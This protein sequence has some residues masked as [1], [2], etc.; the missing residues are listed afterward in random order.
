MPATMSPQLTY[1]EYLSTNQNFISAFG[2]LRPGIDLSQAR[3]ELALLGAAINRAIPSDPDQPDE[4]TSASATTL[5]EAR[6]DKTVRRSLFILLGAVAL[7]H[8]L[9][10]ANVVNLL[11][12]RAAERR[13]ES[14]VRIALGSSGRR[15]F[16]HLVSEGLTL[17]LLGGAFGIALAAWA[18]AVI[19]PPTNVWA[20][21]N[22][23]GSLAPFDAPA[24]RWA[25]MA[26]GIA[27]VG[28]TA[29][30]ISIPPALAAFRIDVS[31]GIKAGSR[32]IA[33]GGL[34]LRR[35][36]S[37]G[38]IVGLEAALAML[39]VVSA[40]LLIESFSR[41]QKAGLGVEPENVLTFWVIP[42]EARVPPA[43]APEFVSRILEAITS[44]PG[45]VSA[46]VDGGGPL[47]GTANS[48]L[49]VIGR[50]DPAPGQAPAVLRHYIAPDH[51]R[52]LAIPCCE[53]GASPTPIPQAAR[54]SS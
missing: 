40:G 7:L 34:S 24:F 25:E 29:L 17:S 9:A 4:R 48:T 45:V 49:Y 1:T 5:N 21:R 30:L 16:R 11:L 52:T 41:M 39:L 13:R 43:A 42:S 14:A 2:R 53:G 47:S 37:R 33:P 18:T 12:G 26:F 10:C 27:L 36:S 38:V 51:F 22:F 44:V 32:G 3:S 6:I 46:S 50:P 19:A 15:L 31:A 54:G 35:P 20:P 28:L 23:Y 8:L